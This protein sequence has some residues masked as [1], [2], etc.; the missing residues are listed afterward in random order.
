MINETPLLTAEQRKRL[1]TREEKKAS[2][3][4]AYK[5]RHNDQ[6]VLKKFGD[7]I[8][9]APD[10]LLILKYMPPEKIAKKLRPD[11]IP[12]ML[13]LVEELLAR[14]DPWPI[15]V[16]E[17][18][19]EARAFRIF[20]NSIPKN[21]DRVPGKCAIFSI[22]RT[23]TC[24]EAEL[25]H[26][27]TDH[28]N[29]IR[30]YVDPCSVDPVCRDPEYIGMLGEQ[31]FK[32][33]KE[34]GIPFSVSQNAYLDET[35][36]SETGWILR[37]PSMVNIDQLQWMRWKP[38]GLKECIEQ[39]PILASKKIPRGKELMHLRIRSGEDG[40][41][42]LISEE[43]GKERS[44]TLDEYLKAHKKLENIN[45]IPIEGNMAL[46]GEEENTNKPK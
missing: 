38:E 43:G 17:D 8:D 30:C 34:L 32:I 29:A 5:K 37:K 11:Q 3:L 1:I 22:S 12:A 2:E 41:Q 46:S 35:G 9:S 21:P 33:R 19:S 31:I 4:E 16:S 44:I 6:V 23:A 27:L 28:F 18:E 36:V 25:D 20:G 15:G 39:P 40:I 7:Y 13:D 24:E 26:C 42:Y 10:I 45:S 14:I